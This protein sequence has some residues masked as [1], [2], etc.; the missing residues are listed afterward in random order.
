M[1]GDDMVMPSRKVWVAYNN[2]MTT[3]RVMDFE[4]GEVR[5]ERILAPDETPEAAIDTL[6]L[7]VHK[8]MHD[9][10]ADLAD[11]DR[12][13]HRAKALARDH[14]MTLPKPPPL[15]AQPED[16]VL[17]DIVPADAAMQC[18][19]KT[20][21]Q[22]HVIGADGT[23]HTVLTYRA[24]FIPGFYGKLASRYAGTV[25]Q[26]AQTHELSPSLILAIMQTESAFNP[27]A[28]SPIPAYGL[29]Q[30]V[31]QSGALD[32]YLY[33]YDERRLLDAE[34]LFHPMYNI[35]LGTAYL[36]LLDSRYLRA[37]TNPQSRLYCTIAAYN[38]GAGR[39]R[40]P[41]P[42][43]V[44]VV[45]LQEMGRPCPCLINYKNIWTVSRRR[46]SSVSGSK[47]GSPAL[48]Q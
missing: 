33:L 9:T 10:P 38:T 32:A 42:R 35:E 31:P 39:C 24:P 16:A 7:D 46:R 34:Y 6:R 26:Q 11:Q 45:K 29:M 1:W 22:S 47:P 4:H 5:V 21:T 3:R 37:I 13:M 14:G 8:A 48:R 25:M 17:K 36:K 12:T 43:H 18:T 28:I 41:G 40:R 19:M 15:P 30:L 23:P 20:V 27:R 2:E 44:C